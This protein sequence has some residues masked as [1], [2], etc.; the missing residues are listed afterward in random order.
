MKNTSV[1]AVN[2]KPLKF[3]MKCFPAM[4]AISNICLRRVSVPSRRWFNA[5]SRPEA[6]ATLVLLAR[7]T[8]FVRVA[9]D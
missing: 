8:T 1:L 3:S 5:A 9:G 4:L 2:I 7:S 6:V